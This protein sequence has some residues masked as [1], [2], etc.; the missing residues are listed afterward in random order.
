MSPSRQHFLLTSGLLISLSEAAKFT[1]YSSEYL[2]YLVRKGKLE[3]V[4]ISRDW[5]TTK[6]IVLEY[7]AKQEARQSKLFY[8]FQSLN[9]KTLAGGGIS[10]T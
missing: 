9:S 3:A 2:G 6:E 8:K 1:P 10:K 5:M 7:V 4:K